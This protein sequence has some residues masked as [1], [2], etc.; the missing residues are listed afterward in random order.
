MSEK[1]EKKEKKD[2]K[3]KRIVRFRHRVI[4]KLVYLPGML[5][6]KILYGSKVDR[7]QGDHKRQYLILYN[8][9][10]DFD[11]ILLGQAFRFPVYYL[12]MEDILSNG[13][14]SAILRYAFAPIAIKKQT[15]D[16]KALRDCF[17]VVK[18]GGSIAIAPEGHRTYSGRPCYINPSI[19]KMIRKLK[20]PVVL[21][22]IEG[23]YGTQPRWS[24]VIRRGHVHAYPS[25]VIEPEEYAALTNDEFYERIR[26]GLAV[27]ETKLPGE[28]R[29][30]KLAEYL[31]RVAY[32][33]PDCG[34]APHES[35][36]DLIRCTSCG[37][38]VRYLPDKT[39]EGVDRPFPFRYAADWYEYQC[40][41]INRMDP[42]VYKDRAAA[43]DMGSLY[44]VI[45]YKKK[46]LLREN[47][48]L[49]LYGDRIV[50]DAGTETELC[51]PF[52]EVPVTL[53]GRNKLNLYAGDEVLQVRGSVRFNAL[54]YLNF[55]N[56]WYNLHKGDP[57]ST[58]LGM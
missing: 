36:D 3:D 4:R 24:N 38:T 43:E 29:H 14:S 48:R 56:R 46:E 35:K 21:F 31:E 57:R 18:E 54:K 32:I 20:L 8:H 9:E 34:I 11:Q 30:K 51:L 26:V 5:L 22:R 49:T 10:S 33:C 37:R 25:E 2:K 19:V 55:Y 6:S 39:L 52:E 28:F 45:L 16:L 58:Y 13:L 47:A 27:D 41:T 42:E 7:L 44:R 50:V 17:Q 23:A 12:A 15:I 40:D 53:L 1:K